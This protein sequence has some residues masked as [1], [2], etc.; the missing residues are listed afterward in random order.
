MR[1]APIKLDAHEAGA[2][3]V[4][5]DRHLGRGAEPVIRD[6]GEPCLTR[7]RRFRGEQDC[8]AVAIE[9]GSAVRGVSN[10]VED[11]IAVGVGNESLGGDGDF[12]VLVRLRGTG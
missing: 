12:E 5:V 10:T 2:A 9:A 3:D 6:N 11:G 4:N 8:A 7:V 1:R